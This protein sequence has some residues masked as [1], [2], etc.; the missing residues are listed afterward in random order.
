MCMVSSFNQKADQLYYDEVG[1][2]TV[3]T[4]AEEK[5]L[6]RQYYTCPVCTKPWPRTIPARNCNHCKAVLPDNLNNQAHTCTTCSLKV[7]TH[8]TPKSCPSC[9]AARDDVSREK[10]IT[11][12]LRFVIRTAKRLTSNPSHLRKLVSAGNVGLLIA[13]D[14]FNINLNFRFLTYASWWIRKEMLDEMNGSSS[15]VH[16]PTYRQKQ[17]RKAIR[18]GPYICVYC[19]V[20][21]QNRYGYGVST[22]CSH[23]AH[24]FRQPVEYSYATLGSAV[25]LDLLDLKAD[26]DVF[27]GVL[28]RRTGVYLREVLR[29]L[30]LN[31]R[32]LFILL[33]FF[34][35]PTG[36]RKN[37][38]KKLPQLAEMTGITT[39]RVRQI[40]ERA[41]LKLRAELE[42]RNIPSTRDVY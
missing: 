39:E 20:R 32:D 10:L 15:P 42:K 6:L 5:E 24:D 4:P 23:P 18:E 40:K 26:H 21:T 30:Q 27:R 35:I 19:G 11:G 31:P 37:T 22:A 9:G 36:T 33:G 16:V 7:S 2:Y 13:V 29:S 17:L 41:L 1:K 38:P 28:E 12:N 14:R 34:D 8:C 25:S 3:L